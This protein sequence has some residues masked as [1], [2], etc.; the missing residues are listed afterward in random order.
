[1]RQTIGCL[2]WE[3]DG[4][5][6]AMTVVSHAGVKFGQ[7]RVERVL[8]TSITDNFSMT[9]KHADENRQAVVIICLN[10]P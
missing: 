8:Q 3:C 4:R 9:K 5:V 10:F 7:S 6:A 1:M 2:L